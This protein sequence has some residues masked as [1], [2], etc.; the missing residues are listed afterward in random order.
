MTD[1]KVVLRGLLRTPT[2]TAV[3]V[4]TLAPPPASWAPVWPLSGSNG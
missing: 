4:L 3:V 1:L 2:F